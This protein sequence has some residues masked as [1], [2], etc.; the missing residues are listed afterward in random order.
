M[1]SSAGLPERR[2]CLVR[3]LATTPVRALFTGH[4]LLRSG[5][6]ESKDNVVA[7]HDQYYTV[8]KGHNPGIYT[9]W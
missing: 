5:D 3:A 6:S 4:F 7:C 8:A 1:L 9:T 2:R